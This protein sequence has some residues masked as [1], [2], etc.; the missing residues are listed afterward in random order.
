MH[1]IFA[2]NLNTD[3]RFTE[4]FCTMIKYRCNVTFAIESILFT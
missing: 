2:I 1:A 4:Q 3:Y